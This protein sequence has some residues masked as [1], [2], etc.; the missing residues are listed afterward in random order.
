MDSWEP[1]AP[2]AR[3]YSPARA[4]PTL[5]VPDKSQHVTRDLNNALRKS[6]VLPF[7]VVSSRIA[8]FP[9]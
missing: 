5:P 4:C 9:C 6:K 8:A 7:H 1:W 2:S 3:P